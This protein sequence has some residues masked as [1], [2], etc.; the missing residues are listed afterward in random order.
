MQDQVGR[1]SGYRHFGD[2]LVQIGRKEGV[3]ALYAGFQVNTLRILPQ[4]AITFLCYE[5]IKNGIDAYD[6]ARR[7][8]R[9]AT[10][11]PSLA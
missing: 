9:Y 7:E 3:R 11:E 4:C 10:H 6:A 1:E 5:Y 8:F 2:A